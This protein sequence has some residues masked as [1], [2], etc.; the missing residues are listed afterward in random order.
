MARAALALASWTAPEGRGARWR[1]ALGPEGVDGSIDLRDES[2]NAN[3]ASMAAA[4][5]V[6][7]AA[8]PEDG[9]G[10][11]TRGRRIAI[12]GDMLELGAD[13]EALHAGLA[14]LPAMEAVD[15]VICA[16]PR[17]HALHRAL[18]TQKR[19]GWFETSKEAA[20]RA[21]RLVDA[22]DVATVKG[23][24][25]SKMAR[26]VEALKDLGEARPAS[27]PEEDRD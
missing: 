19:G 17:M 6:L 8:R 21:R 16:G 4:L 18:P 23:S 3:P 13:E 10:R 24:L 2:Y 25:G 14:E 9:V 27:A 26:V 7:V 11:V 1:I 12:L 5:E 20:E 15:L 22:G